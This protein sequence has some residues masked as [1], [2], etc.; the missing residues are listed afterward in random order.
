MKIRFLISLVV[1]V[2][3]ASLP[4]VISSCGILD[5]EEEEVKLDCDKICNKE[6]ECNKEMT[7]DDLRECKTQ[8]DGVSRSGYFQNTIIKTINSCYDKTCPEIDSCVEKGTGSCKAPNYMPFVSAACD[9]HIEC[10]LGT[11]KDTCTTEFKNALDKEINEGEIVRCLTD[12]AFSDLGECMK[13]ANCQT[14]E[15]DLG[16]CMEDLIGMK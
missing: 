3:V 15:D 11:T 4:F 12:K 16:K 2:V 6:K 8:C 10:G 14:I 13:K 7:D 9:K 5:D 1:T